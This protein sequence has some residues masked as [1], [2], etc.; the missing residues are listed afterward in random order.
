MCVRVGLF[1]ESKIFYVY[2]IVCEHKRK[3]ERERERGRERKSKELQ[4][5]DPI[6]LEL[7]HNF[8]WLCQNGL[9]IE[10]T[11]LKD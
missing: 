11:F 9:A 2:V 7:L 8:D 5:K 3:R 4:N 10:E 1:D 6:Q